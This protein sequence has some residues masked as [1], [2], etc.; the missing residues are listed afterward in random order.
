MAAMAA[1]T[2]HGRKFSPIAAI[3]P[4][5]RCRMAPFCFL[6]FFAFFAAFAREMAGREGPRGR[7]NRVS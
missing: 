2:P 3:G 4:L 1:G 7:G 5:L 6:S